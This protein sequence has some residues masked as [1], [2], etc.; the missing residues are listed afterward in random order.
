MC[1]VD[2]GAAEHK[3]ITRSDGVVLICVCFGVVCAELCAGSF[4]GYIS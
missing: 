3:M 2:S 1:H 4:G